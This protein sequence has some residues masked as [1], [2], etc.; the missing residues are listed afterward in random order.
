MGKESDRRKQIGGAVGGG[1][2]GVEKNRGV[3]NEIVSGERMI[4]I[5]AMAVGALTSAAWIAPR[6]WCYWFIGLANLLF[7]MIKRVP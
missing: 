7:I 4:V 3:W 5:T 6:P 2:G 1:V